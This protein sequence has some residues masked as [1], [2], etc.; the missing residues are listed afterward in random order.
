M[1]I[2]DV[3]QIH[4]T[5]DHI[6]LSPHLDDVALSCGGAIAHAVEMGMSVL[7]VTI[8]TAIPP[9]DSQFSSFAQDMHHRWALS[10]EEVVT[11][12]LDEDREAMARLGV[13]SYWAGML[14]AIY[15]RPD[16]YNT[17]AAL[18]GTP[19]EDD[20]LAPILKQFIEVLHARAPRASFYAP[21]GVGGH[22]DHRLTYKAVV[23]R[24]QLMTEFYED[25]PYVAQVGALEQR[26]AELNL[27]FAART[28]NIATT[29]P[30]KIHAIEA[31]GS[32]L[33]QLFG[34][35]DQMRLLVTQ[36]AERLRSDHS[37]YNERLWSVTSNDT[38]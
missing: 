34:G 9:P 2:E 25:F 17:D 38:P 29:L 32:Q 33:D 31:Y 19:A 27:M 26:F 8:C 18:F 22:V 14:D 12:R 16:I 36:Y 15:R 23:E 37:L 24:D 6:Y 1:H 11:A 13:D 20:P 30:R 28:V 7:A 35:A 5:Y 21:L 3:R 10:P 4:D